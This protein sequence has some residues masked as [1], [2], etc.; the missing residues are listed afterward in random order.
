MSDLTGKVAVIT[1]G[2][3]GIG[4]ASAQELKNRGVHVAITGRSA[5]SLQNASRQL[6]EDVLSFQGD[7]TD[8]GHLE[9]V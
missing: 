5:E 6:G 1:G 2:N 7:V 8:I 9:G 3:S 4:L